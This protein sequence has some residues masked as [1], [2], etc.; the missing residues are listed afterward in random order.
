MLSRFE[1]LV[2]V[3]LAVTIGVCL[4]T[5]FSFAEE[6]KE[7]VKNFF[8]RAFNYTGHTVKATA[9]TGVTAAK[10]VGTVTQ[11]AV[12]NTASVATGDV[13][14]VGDLAVEPVAQSAE[15]VVQTT[16]QAV[17]IPVKAGEETEKAMKE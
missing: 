11:S 15:T 2:R 9:E 13:K 17:Q 6:K 5:S 7:P 3:I 14:K 4:L 16:T 12:E 8:K 1:S 10:G